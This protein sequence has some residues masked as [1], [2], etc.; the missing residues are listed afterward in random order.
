ME[1]HHWIFQIRLQ[2]T[3]GLDQNILNHIA[4]V[5]SSLD[6]AIQS[7]THQV[8][9]GVSVTIDQHVYGIVIATAYLIQQFQRFV[10]FWPHNY[11]Y[12]LKIAEPIDELRESARA[13]GFSVI[14][15]CIA[16]VKFA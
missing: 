5:D 11:Y 16:G 3:V 13:N 4:D 2:A 6:L 12:S 10:M 1:R 9:Q 8:T 14:C 15:Y 7:H